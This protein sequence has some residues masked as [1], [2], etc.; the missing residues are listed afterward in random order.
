V[1]SRGRPP[2]IAT[3]LRD[4]AALTARH[5]FTKFPGY[6]IAASHGSR[7]KAPL[8]GSR[9]ERIACVTPADLDH[10]PAEPAPKRDAEASR[11]GIAATVIVAFVALVAAVYLGVE[12]RSAGQARDAVQA[13]LDTVQQE[14]AALKQ[15]G[16]DR[17]GLKAESNQMKVQL[18]QIR[19]ALADTVK[20]RDQ[21]GQEAAAAEAQVKSVQDRLAGAEAE[22]AS[23]RTELGGLDS[24]LDQLRSQEAA[25]RDSYGRLNAAAADVNGQLAQATDQLGKTQGDLAAARQQL[26]DLQTQIA[27]TADE[28]KRQAETAKP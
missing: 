17:D 23:K 10:S 8:K 28:M 13:K 9:I 1:C 2:A 14:L 6:G 4:R 15:A 22:A 11:I 3:R 12:S 16:A 5:D 7:R 24:Q 26:A 19:G 21:A 25:Q 20:R 27:R 18:D